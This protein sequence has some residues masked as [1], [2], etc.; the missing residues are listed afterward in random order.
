MIAGRVFHRAPISPLLSNLYMRRFIL[1]WQR[2]SASRR[3]DARIVNYADDLVILCRRARPTR[4]LQRCGLMGRLKLTVNEER[5]APAAGRAHFDFLGYLRTVLHI[6]LAAPT[7]GPDLRRR[8]SGVS[9]SDWGSSPIQGLAG[10]KPRSLLQ[11]LNRTL[12]GWANF[13]LVLARPA[14]LSDRRG[15]LRD[16]VSPVVAQ[17]T[18]PDVT[19]CSPI[20]TSICSGLWASFGYPAERATCRGRGHDVCPRARCRKTARRVR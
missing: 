3:L 4:P 9:S 17:S 5:R 19:G 13:L 8:V 20:P 1:G 2:W 7:W 16:A 11:S 12:T 18:S 6:E 10:R 14:A 15:V